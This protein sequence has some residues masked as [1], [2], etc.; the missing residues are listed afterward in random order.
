MKN[1]FRLIRTSTFVD[2]EE[3]LLKDRLED[4][5]ALAPVTFVAYDPCP[6]FVI[7]RNSSG[8]Q[9]CLRDDLF[10]Y[11]DTTAGNPGKSTVAS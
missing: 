9:R 6:A 1:D 5:P 4:K 8:R 2:G 11:P 10:T 7:V 3:Y